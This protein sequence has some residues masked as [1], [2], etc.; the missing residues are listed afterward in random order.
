MLLRGI[1]ED[2]TPSTMREGGSAE[3]VKIRFEAPGG[4]RDMSR[5]QFRGILGSPSRTET[6]EGM[7]NSTTVL[8]LGLF[9]PR[10]GIHY[11][12]LHLFY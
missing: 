1:I 9:Q 2:G 12:K 3:R 10:G 8:L 11:L 7:W 6:Y 5:S 4:I